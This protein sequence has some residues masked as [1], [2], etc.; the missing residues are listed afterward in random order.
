MT[1][2]LAFY[3]EKYSHRK[4][5]SS[6]LDRGTGIPKGDKSVRKIP[7]IILYTFMLKLA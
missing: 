7:V 4:I 6:A 2:A 5:V 3:K 1:E